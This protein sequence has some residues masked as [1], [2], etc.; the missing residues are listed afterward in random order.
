MC[1][2]ASCSQYEEGI[3]PFN[4]LKPGGEMNELHFYK[5]KPYTGI[6]IKKDKEEDWVY[7]LSFKDGY[8][9][10]SQID[11]HD[12]FLK[13]SSNYIENERSSVSNLFDK[14]G[15][16]TS[17]HNYLE[18]LPHGLHEMYYPNGN[19]LYRYYMNKGKYDGLYQNFEKNGEIKSSTCYRNGKKVELSHCNPF[20]V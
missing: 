17:K 5:G 3:V 10:G 13:A 9:H 4:S 12:G 2:V 6:S 7:I 8:I 11:I 19:I 18:G 14:N 15:N 16:I 20:K 1:L